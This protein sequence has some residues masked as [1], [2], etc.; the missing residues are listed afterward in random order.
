VTIPDNTIG[1]GATLPG[2]DSQDFDDEG[3]GERRLRRELS[4][5]GPSVGALMRAG[6]ACA[7]QWPV[8]QVLIDSITDEKG[9]TTTYTTQ[10]KVNLVDVGCDG[11]E[12]VARRLAE[13]TPL[14]MDL[15]VGSLGSLKVGQHVALRS[16]S[17]RLQ[18]VDGVKTAV[19]MK[20]VVKSSDADETAAK[21]EDIME[22]QVRWA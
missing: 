21:A 15:P 14:L 4:V 17:R 1:Y 11:K 20:L 13:D 3:T 5:G 9:V 7:L 10:S 8:A 22:A 6:V 12:I 2:L 19:N 18:E 16:V